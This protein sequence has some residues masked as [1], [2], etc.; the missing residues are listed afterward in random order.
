VLSVSHRAWEQRHR[1]DQ[2]EQ[3]VVA[4]T[5]VERVSATLTAWAILVSTKSDR[6]VRYRCAAAAPP[7]Q[8]KKVFYFPCLNYEVLWYNKY[9]KLSNK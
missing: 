7:V 5:L 9:K 6:V 2:T 1:H 8:L 3:S 4:A